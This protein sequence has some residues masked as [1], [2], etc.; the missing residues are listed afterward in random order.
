MMSVHGLVRWQVGSLGWYSPW[1]VE[2]VSIIRRKSCMDS[3]LFSSINHSITDMGMSA[4]VAR[5]RSSAL[6][7]LACIFDDVLRKDKLQFT[8]Q[9]KENRSVW[10]FSGWTSVLVVLFSSVFG[11]NNNVVKYPVLHQKF[12]A[13]LSLILIRKV[14]FVSR[15]A[16]FGWLNLIRWLLNED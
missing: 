8:Q 15:Y 1:Y 14:L 16:A 6:S 10:R 5:C 3:I 12:S 2:T 7:S 11:C 13:R 9:V 4:M